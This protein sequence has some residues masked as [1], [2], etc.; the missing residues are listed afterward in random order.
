MKIINKKAIIPL[1]YG[2]MRA[3]ER[4]DIETAKNSL[5]HMARK[6]LEIDG[7]VP[8]HVLIDKL[9]R[10]TKSIRSGCYDKNGKLIS[11]EENMR[12]EISDTFDV[13]Q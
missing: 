11:E 8:K 7:T 10:D 5:E 9:G 2:S 1:L 3:L 4:D 6:V 12:L 13:E